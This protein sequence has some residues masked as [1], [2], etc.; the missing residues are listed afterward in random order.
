MKDIKRNT[1]FIEKECKVAVIVN[2]H[3]HGN[4]ASWAVMCSRWSSNCSLHSPNFVITS[5]LLMTRS[6][7]F[8]N[9]KLLLHCSYYRPWLGYPPFPPS[10]L[11]I[12]A[13]AVCPH[14]CLSL[15]PCFLSVV[16]MISSL[17]GQSAETT[18]D[19]QR[20]R[21]MERQKGRCRKMRGGGNLMDEKRKG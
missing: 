14:F 9:C 12:V 10:C 16:S 4:S 20:Y 5:F 2:K 13:C 6:V 1:S 11:S 21:V 19:W 8:T 15:L 17:F 3:H 7:I 18:A